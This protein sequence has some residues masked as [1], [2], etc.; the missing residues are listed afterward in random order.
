MHGHNLLYSS[1]SEISA[2]GD[3]GAGSCFIFWFHIR[4]FS[5]H[6]VS[7]SL[8]RPSRPGKDSEARIL[9]L[10]AD[11]LHLVMNAGDEVQLGSHQLSG[12]FTNTLKHISNQPVCSKLPSLLGRP[13]SSTR[14]KRPIFGP[15][16]TESYAYVMMSLPGE[17]EPSRLHSWWGMG[18]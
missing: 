8:L 2:A 3:F 13:G 17:R 15:H 9:I 5:S 6:R 16:P 18:P 11:I 12:R 4:H 14:P 10:Q 7:T 1:G